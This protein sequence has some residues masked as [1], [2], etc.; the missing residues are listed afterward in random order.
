MK[1]NLVSIEDGLDNIGFRKVTAYVKAVL[2]DTGIFYLTTG[3]V[4]SLSRILT[5]KGVE[6]FQQDD[7]QVIAGQIANAD[8]V[9]FSSM[10]PYAQLTADIIA[11]VRTRNP[12]ATIV[13]G[14]IHPIIQPEDAIKHADAIC[15]GEGELAFE[16]FLAA[17]Q[18]GCHGLGVPGFWVNSP[19][20]IVKMNNLPLMTGEEMDRLP[21]L[22]YQD[23]ELIYKKGRGFVPTT[24]ADYINNC[25][26]AYNTVWSIGCPMNCIYCGN[27][28]FLAYDSNYRKV[29]HSSPATIVAEIKAAVIKHRHIST[30]V[31]HDD[32]FMALPFDVLKEFSTLFR[33]EIG[34]PFAVIGLIPNYVTEEK[35]ELLVAHGMNRVRM[36]IQSGS[37]D[38]LDFYDRPTS[39]KRIRESCS[40]LNKFSPYMIPP[41]FDIIVDNPIET[42]AD[43]LAT[44]DLLYEMPRPYTLNIFSLR[45]IPNTRLA[46]AL[47]ARNV[48]VADINSTYA[49]HKPTFANVLIYLIV[50][51]KL[52]RRLYLK[53]RTKALPSQLEQQMYPGLL[54]VCRLLY[55]SK[56]AFEHLR[57][58]DFTVLTGPLGYILWKLGLIG[59]WQRNTPQITHP[60]K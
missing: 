29:R 12:R 2:P 6:P 8:V 28:K 7:I 38:V 40:A 51:F 11:A 3:N 23:G 4:R 1:I 55:L 54:L 30:V 44:L 49:W 46:A 45:V 57:F 50:L 37:Q 17:L 33:S 32:S 25:G 53:L 9:G 27:S 36:G 26:L 21:V 24:H 14:G 41:A 34:L 13:W 48:V 35:L 18:D 22:T 15:T 58:M 31:F 42:T 59:F 60:Q 56:R 10:T 52:P 43:T 47:A 16:L 20:G 39:I 5:M 19:D